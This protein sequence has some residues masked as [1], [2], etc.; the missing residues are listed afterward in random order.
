[1]MAGE[2]MNYAGRPDGRYRNN[3]SGFPGVSLHKKSGRWQALIGYEGRNYHI[4]LFDTP[5]AAHQA[6]LDVCVDPLSFPKIRDDV[7][8]SGR[9]VT[10]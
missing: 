1:M 4:G 3:K 10:P 9:A 8:S 7:E 6:Y 2:A 5:E